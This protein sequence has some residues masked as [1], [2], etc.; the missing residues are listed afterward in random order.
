[1]AHEA[2]IF[3]RIHAQVLAVAGL[4]ETAMRRLAHDHEMSVDPA[5]A[6]AQAG[7]GRH[8]ARDIPRPDRGCQ[9]IVRII[10]PADCLLDLLERR[11]RYHGSEHFAANDLIVLRRTRHYGGLVEESLARGGAAAARV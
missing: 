11:D 9:S 10:G 5:A 4:L 6:I 1:M 2:V 7:R 3:E 8:G